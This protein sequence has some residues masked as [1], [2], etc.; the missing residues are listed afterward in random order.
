MVLRGL[1]IYGYTSLARDIA[2]RFYQATRAIWQKTGTIWENYSPEQCE[3]PL[4]HGQDFCGWSA[5][6]PISIYRE[7]V[8]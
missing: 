3:T 5:L 4:P 8:I 6:A 2:G 7:F 1:Q